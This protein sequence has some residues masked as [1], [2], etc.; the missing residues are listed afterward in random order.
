MKKILKPQFYFLIVLYT[1]MSLSKPGAD[2][3]SPYNDLFL[4]FIGY[5]ILINSGLLAFGTKSKK[6]NMFIYLF[7]YSFAIELIQH[8]IPYR[9]F[10]LLDLMANALGLFVGLIIGLTILRLLHR[11]GLI[12]FLGPQS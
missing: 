9:E 2:L 4:H 3:A 7:S 10:S 6:I 8:F 11:T 1:Y 12:S 5:A